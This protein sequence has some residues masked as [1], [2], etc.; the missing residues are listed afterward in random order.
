MKPLLVA[1]AVAFGLS[2]SASAA[3][4][5]VGTGQNGGVTIDEGGT[6]YVGWL[7][8]TGELG[9]AVQ[10]CVLPG[11]VRACVSNVTVAFPG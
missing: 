6:A 4:I 3:P 5:T 10:L 9:D 1:A 11:A 8:N 2:G 7:V